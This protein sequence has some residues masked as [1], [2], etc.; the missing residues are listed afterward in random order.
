ME[1]LVEDSVRV[2]TQFLDINSLIS[3]SLTSNRYHSLFE[4]PNTNRY[5]AD[6]YDFPY[7]LPF[8]SVM[9]YFN[10]RPVERLIG[11]I[12]AGDDRMINIIL[13]QVKSEEELTKAL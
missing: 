2:I 3:L 9:S 5:L 12:E 8:T 6:K 1:N 13:P 11:A 7:D 4:D 10:L